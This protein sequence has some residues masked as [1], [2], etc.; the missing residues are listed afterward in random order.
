MITAPPLCLFRLVSPK[1]GGLVDRHDALDQ[2]VPFFFE[3]IAVV[4]GHF[5]APER[6]GQIIDQA[7][8]AVGAFLLPSWPVGGAQDVRQVVIGDQRPSHADGI[9][10][11]VADYAGDIGG[12]LK[13]A[14]AQELDAGVDLDDGA[15]SA[16]TGEDAAKYAEA[17]WSGKEWA[18]N[19]AGGGGGE[20]KGRSCEQRFG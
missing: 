4:A 7:F 11:A 5:V 10:R 20:W 3:C 12:V 16:V 19:S 6:V 15:T 13:A 9:A 1:Q 2:S 8:V 17:N 18:G 14:G